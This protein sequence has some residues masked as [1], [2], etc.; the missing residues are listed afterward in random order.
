MQVGGAFQMLTNYVHRVRKSREQN[1]RAAS[2]N[3]NAVVVIITRLN[4]IA[5]R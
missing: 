3:G 4:K 5:I 2:R 1:V